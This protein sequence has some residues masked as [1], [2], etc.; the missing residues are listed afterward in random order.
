MIQEQKKGAKCPPKRSVAV[1]LAILFAVAFLL[2]LL[3]YFMQ[4]RSTESLI[5]KLQAS[6]SNAEL[7]NELIDENRALHVENTALMGQMDELTDSLEDATEQL[8]ECQSQVE[9][10]TANLDTAQEFSIC[11]YILHWVQ[12]QIDADNYEGAA[13]VLAHS[14]PADKLL[15]TLD[16]F[17]HSGGPEFKLVPYYQALVDQLLDSGYLAQNENGTLSFQSDIPE[18][19]E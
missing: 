17:D 19:L 5:G 2:L 15:A 12:A 16:A 13:S 9:S 14:Y 4:E 11:L 18:V 8:N 10:L 6:A 1:Y 7:L 3:A